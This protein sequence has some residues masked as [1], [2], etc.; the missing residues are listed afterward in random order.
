MNLYCV[1][2]FLRKKEIGENFKLHFLKFY[3]TKIWKIGEKKFG[4]I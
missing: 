2:D 1:L 4:Q 3:I